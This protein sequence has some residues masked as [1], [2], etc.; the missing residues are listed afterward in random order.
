[1]AAAQKDGKSGNATFLINFLAGGVS[2][3]VSK[4]VVAPLERVKLL[5]QVQDASTQ[6]GD[7]GT[8][9]YKGFVDCFVRVYHEQGVVSYWRGNWANVLRYFPTQA[10]NFAFKEKYQKFF[11]RHDPKT[12][13]WKFFMGNLASGGAA[14]AT[15]LLFVYPLDFARTRL[16][17]DVGKAAQ[18]R[19]FT[20]LVDCCG[21]IFKQDGVRGLYYGFGVSVAGIIVYRAAFFGLYDT[22]KAMLYRDPKKSNP[23]VSFTLGLAVETAAGVVAYPFD[24]VRRRLM[25]QA[26]RAD[27]LY[28]STMDCARRILTEEGA[29]AF[30]KG[31]WS[32]VMRGVGGAIVLVLYDEIKKAIPA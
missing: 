5:L 29:A 9:K 18:E 4:T 19:H 28:S 20:G 26:G 22:A 14:G 11:V 6:I 7:G 16:G 15:S 21:K 27:V 23:L 1:M 24:T 31:C 30:F 3:G 12:D 25:M 32:N 17:A 10:L 13:F 8:K 2:G